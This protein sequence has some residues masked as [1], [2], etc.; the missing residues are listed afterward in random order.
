MVPRNGTIKTI[1]NTKINYK[2]V[3]TKVIGADCCNGRCFISHESYMDAGNLILLRF[4][5]QLPDSTIWFD[6]SLIQN[7]SPALKPV[8]DLYVK[9]IYQTQTGKIL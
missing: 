1:P 7:R 8:L 5:F 9:H 3:E 4:K 2:F 6:F